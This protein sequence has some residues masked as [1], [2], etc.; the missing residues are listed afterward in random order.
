MAD[1]PALR[2]RRA[3]RHRRGDHSDCDPARR[4]ESREQGKVL[5]A[6]ERPGPPDPVDLVPAGQ[7][8]G[9]A[10][11][12]GPRG[13][14]LR[15]AF[16]DAPFNALQ[17]LLLDEAARMADRLDRLDEALRNRGTWMRI[18]VDDGGEIVVHI[19]SVLAEARQQ[20]TALRGIVAELV[21]ALPRAAE[22]EPARGGA[23]AD[24]S[25]RIA[26]RRGTSAG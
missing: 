12:Y 24:L 2:A 23:L 7:R 11:P 20:A 25:A 18:E 14:A 9:D 8:K 4:C 19:D 1:S 15:E 21:K 10:P 22:Q 5:E 16:A 13:A 6:L 26:A 17:R 3:R